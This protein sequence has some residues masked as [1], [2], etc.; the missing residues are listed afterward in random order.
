MEKCSLCQVFILPCTI[1]ENERMLPKIPLQKCPGYICQTTL[2]CLPKKRRCDNIIDCLHGDDE[3]NCEN[4]E[5]NEFFANLVGI[6]SPANVT[7]RK[8]TD[9]T[10]D[11]NENF[12]ITD[13]NTKH[14][15]TLKFRC[16]KYDCSSVILHYIMFNLCTDC[17]SK[18]QVTKGAI[19]YLTV[20]MEQ[21]RRIARASSIF[22]I[23]TRQQFAM[24]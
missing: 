14:N 10:V 20:K 24:E 11:S 7:N 6:G 16:K 19:K 2:R 17:C 1:S 3:M 9:E 12:N 8:S 15:Y 5:S 21:M 18:Y 4:R 23:L 22:K 13:A